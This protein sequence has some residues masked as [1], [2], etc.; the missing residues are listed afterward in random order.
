[1][2][3]LDTYAL[4]CG[5]KIDKPY[6]HTMFYPLGEERYITIQ[7]FSNYSGKQ[8][9]YWNE[10][11]SYIAPK[12]EENGIKIV[13]IG[14]KDDSPIAS[15]IWAQGTTTIAQASFLIKNSMLHLGVDSFGV[16]VA[17]A[18]D[19]KIVALYSTN[20]AENCKPYW[21]NPKDCA[22]IEPDRTER[23]PSFQFEDEPPKTINEIKPEFVASA[24]L[25]LLGLEY[26][27]EHE[28]LHIGQSYANFNV[29]VVP[30]GLAS[31]LEPSLP[32]IV[33]RMDLSFNED[34]L[35]D[36]LNKMKSVS[37]FTDKALDTEIVEEHKAKVKEVVYVLDKDNDIEFVKYLHNTGLEYILVTDIDGQELKD[38]KFKYL[39][40]N[41]IF[42]RS[43]N[44]KERLKILENSLGSLVY[45]TNRKIIKNKKAYASVSAL[46]K[47]EPLKDF[48]DQAFSPVID[49]P[50]FW[51]DLEYVYIAKQLD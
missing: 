25:E 39:D 5:L 11:I 31:D 16:H 24:V 28:T 8:Y 38:L 33:I 40:Y 42:K 19:K 44:P 29:H 21:S 37:I 36:I 49:E 43:V 45:K 7:P 10:V 32:H 27:I 23:K 9:D 20:W 13:Q 14:K 18:F 50:E 41:F 51:Q 34:I 47:D 26:K 2:H 22:I 15:C 1:M 3:L 12:L 48:S 6:I 30:E 17:S 46:K 35:Y 4:N